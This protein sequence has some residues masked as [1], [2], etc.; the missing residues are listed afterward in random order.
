MIEVKIERKIDD[1]I[2]EEIKT[3]GWRLL[4]C[5]IEEFGVGIVNY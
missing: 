3:I 5:L 2:A 1:M 4:M